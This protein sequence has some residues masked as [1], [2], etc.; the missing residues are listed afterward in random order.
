M[1]EHSAV[2]RRVASSNLARGAKFRNSRQKRCRFGVEVYRRVRMCAQNGSG[3][4]RA[5]LPFQASLYGARFLRTGNDCDDLFALQDLFHG[6]RDSASGNLGNGFE[7]AFVDLLRAACLIEFDDQ[8]R[9]I[10]FEIGGRI[11]ER[12]VR[13]L[14]DSDEREIDGRGLQCLAL[15][16]GRRPRDSVHR[17]A[18][19]S[20]GYLFFE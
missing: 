2:N 18:A 1:V 7:P 19:G 3:R 9:F 16:R 4:G 6:H 5:N 20:A 15:R 10:G 11:V 12:Q 14:A 17:P 8:I 13:I